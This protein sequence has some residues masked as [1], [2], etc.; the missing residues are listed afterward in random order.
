MSGGR[1]NDTFAGRVWETLGAFSNPNAHLEQHADDAQAAEETIDNAGPPGAPAGAGGV[2]DLY[3]LNSADKAA[4]MEKFNYESSDAV[5]L[6][7]MNTKLRRIRV[8][9]DRDNRKI[10]Q[11]IAATGGPSGAPPDAAVPAQIA[12]AQE[13][14]AVLIA[15]LV[16]FMEED[17]THSLMFEVSTE[18]RWPMTSE[19]A[20]D[21][22]DEMSTFFMSII[23]ITVE[24][25]F[26]TSL[27]AVEGRAAHIGARGAMA[28]PIVNFMGIARGG[29]QPPS[30]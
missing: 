24:K 27:D 15:K 10:E 25:M 16:Q 17:V 28:G 4:M 8:W 26:A 7:I 22:L 11:T 18:N 23:H 29:H 20:V 13:K 14:N 3:G 5:W 19:E 12:R 30:V 9:I 21:Y 6:G 1:S 2:A